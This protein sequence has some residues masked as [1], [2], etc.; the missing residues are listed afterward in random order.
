MGGMEIGPRLLRLLGMDGHADVVE[1]VAFVEALPADGLGLEQERV[2]LS[3]ERLR[4][5]WVGRQRAIDALGQLLNSPL[6]LS[7][8]RSRSRVTQEE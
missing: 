4:R 7:E 2:L 1:R 3:S 5:R 6:Q 8:P